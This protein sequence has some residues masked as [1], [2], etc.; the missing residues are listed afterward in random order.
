MGHPLSRA[1]GGVH[2]RYLDQAYELGVRALDT[3]ASYQLGGTERALGGWI[4]KR[5]RETLFLVTKAGHPHA[6]LVPNRVRKE[7]ILCDVDASLRRLRTDWV[8]L[9]L[10]HRD[11]PRASFD[12][13]LETMERVREQGRC[14]GWGVSNWTP[15]RIAGL[16]ARAHELGLRGPAVSSPQFSLLAWSAP[17][18]PGSVDLS[19]QRNEDARRF[20]ARHRL[21][22]LAWSPLCGGALFRSPLPGGWQGAAN[23]ARQRAARELATRRN[24]SLGAVALAYL[25]AQ[26]FPVV[27]IVAT[28]C[29]DR[30][31]QHVEAIS[32]RLEP[33]ELRALL[34]PPARKN[35]PRQKES[36]RED[37]R[38]QHRGPHAH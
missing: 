31:H 27:P 17:P 19:G 6:F 3:A 34:G 2:D 10:L 5:P 14:R 28:R 8:D 29:I 25:G 11:H 16:A 37:T 9:L 20:Y 26:P 23:E 7:A 30:L 36:L 38:G 12:E 18:W 13:I 15:A 35:D 1:S 21:P 32:T 22:V 24:L 33:A 4:A